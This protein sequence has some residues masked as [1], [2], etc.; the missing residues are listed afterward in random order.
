MTLNRVLVCFLATLGWLAGIAPAIAQTPEWVWLEGAAGD[1]TILVRKTF[2]LTEEVKSA[3]VEG[4]ADNA[5]VA[6]INGKKTIS[7]NDWNGTAAQDVA[8]QLV[9]GKNVIALKVTNEGGPGGGIAQLKIKLASGKDLVIN[10]DASWK[11]SAAIDGDAW[12]KADFDDSAWKTVK[13]VG[14]LGATPWGN[15]GFGLKPAGTPNANYATTE[16]NIT[17]VAGFKTELLYSVPKEEQGSWVSLTSDD[18]NR[19]LACDQYGALYRI[20]PGANLESTKVEKLDVAIGAAHGLLWLNKGLYVVVNGSAAKGD[21]L[22]RVT[23]SKGDDHL[24]TVVLLKKFEGSGEHGP[25]AVKLGPDGRLYVIAG[26]FTKPPAE[27]DPA[28]PARNWAEDLLLPRNPDG[29]GHDPHIMAPGGWVASCDLEGKNWRLIATG[30]RNSYDIDFNTDGELFT[31]DSDMEWDTG[32]PWYRPTRVNHLVSAGEFG[33]RNGTG[34]WPEYSPD[35]LG[36][37]V[38]IG[39]GSPTGVVFGTGAKFPE[40]YQKAFF[41]NDWTYGKI[42]AVHMNPLGATY[43][44]TFETFVSGKPLPVTDLCVHTDGHLYFA[45]GGRRTQSGLYR[46]RYVGSEPT[47]SATKAGDEK[48]SAARK[49]RQSLEA[50]HGKKDPAAI[51]AAWPHL[52]SHDRSIRF[53]AR[54]AVEHQ[55]SNLWAEKAMADS[56]STATIQ[57]MIALARGDRKDLQS[58][59][60]SRLNALPYPNLTEEQITS[61]LRAYSLAFIRLGEPSKADRDAVVAALAPLYPSQSELVNRELS[62]VLAYLQDESMV[63]KSMDLLSKAP[64]QEDQLFYVLVLRNL[65]GGFTLDQR[66]AY[67]SWMNVAEQTGRGGHSFK[68]FVQRIREDALKNVLDGDKA[69]LKEILEGSQKVQA[70]SI[71]TT[72]QFVHNW[73]MDDVLPLIAEVEKGRSFE[74]GKKAYAAGQCAKCHRFAGQGGDTGPDITTVGNKFA[75]AYI[76]ESLIHPSKT[77]SDQYVNQV[78][79]LNSGEVITGRVLEDTGDKIKVRTDPFALKIKE[80]AKS[81]IEERTNSKVS[82]MPEGL[83]NTLTRE[84]LLDLVAYLRSA[85]NAEDKAFKP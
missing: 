81:E 62:Q 16:E 56:R 71:E 72:R 76:M 17:T 11:A 12:S 23:A 85:G 8:K 60:L 13:V 24:D 4:T 20:T 43:T 40:K 59:I 45:I 78:I 54:V 84:E 38:N 29:G 48:A 34:K 41:I 82:E 10:T 55:D 37:V 61:A 36:A 26:N 52:N 53:A 80:I 22:Y 66:K 79:A 51:A 18:K 32:T 70:V 27:Y 57:L 30:L 68:K 31:Y 69:A 9:V 47:S 64:S 58:K 6:Y 28:S 77:I 33:W 25:H 65:K 39:L 42:Y 74:G 67:F 63:A 15:V 2:E 19:L 5:L 35:S 44:G 83:I 7:T 75:P 46:V 1:A 50:F 49:L 3:R 14:K 21:G 73:Q